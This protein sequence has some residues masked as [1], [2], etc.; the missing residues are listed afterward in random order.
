MP[1]HVHHIVRGA[2][3]DAARNEPAGYFRVCAE[4]HEDKMPD[5][6]GQ[7][8]VKRWYDP[9]HYD[10]MKVNLLR[11]RQPEAITERDVEKAARRMGV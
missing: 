5:V 1:L 6:A 4:C 8:A 3:L 7:L 2:N 10:R 9:E 11:G